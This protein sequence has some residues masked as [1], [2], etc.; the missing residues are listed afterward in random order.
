MANFYEDNQDIKFHF[1][2]LDLGHIAWLQEEG[3]R[4]AGHYD[5]APRDEADAVDGYEQVLRVVGDICAEFIAPRAESVDR[6]GS[7]LRED[8]RVSY[9]DGLRES[10]AVLAQA[11]LMGFTLPRRFGGLNFPTIVYTMAIEMVSQADASLMN[12]F[13]LQGIAETINAFASEEL[14][15]EYLPRFSAGEIT[16][17]MALTEPEAGSDLQNCQLKAEEVGEGWWKLTGVKR[18]ITN[19]CGEVLLVLARSEPDRE[20][21]LGLSLFL[22]E[23]SDRLKVRRLEDK[24]GIHG[25]PTCELY[26]DGAPAR[27]IGERQRGLV[28]YVMPLMNG[29][30]IG[31][32]AQALGIAQGAFNE[33]RAYARERVQFGTPIDRIPPVAEMLAEMEVALEAARSVTYE[34]S[35]Q[36][37]EHHGLLRQMEWDDLEEPA[38]REIKGRERQLR[39]L[40]AFLTPLAKYVASE[41]CV[42]ITYDAIQVLGG[43]GFMRDYPLERYYRDARITTIYEGTTQLQ[44]V[45]AVRGVLSGVAETYFKRLEAHTY[46]EGTRRLQ[47]QLMRARELLG[48]AVTYLKEKGG[49]D[50]TELYARPLVDVAYDILVGYLFL[51]QAGHSRHKLAVARRAITRAMPR[52]RMN[53]SYVTSG[54]RSTLRQ[55]TQLVPDPLAV[56]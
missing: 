55:F 6:E 26:F 20:G 41:T 3:F 52:I 49:Y 45:A 29:A 1:H 35:C 2:T 24:M 37:D 13:G 23:R 19:G 11:D 21:G 56:E 53:C 14:K 18:F 16:G 32:A 15:Q 46:P 12:V 34:S 25:S 43:S 51:G 31:I 47:R 9:A 17:A 28:S 48:K 5:Y 42:K 40:N 27:L 44:I 39:R 54:E 36:V 33:A 30:R 4:D 38:L 7:V 8:G 10:L 22:C 50:Y